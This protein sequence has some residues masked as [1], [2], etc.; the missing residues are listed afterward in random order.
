MPSA[1]RQSK[2]RPC[3]NFFG[4]HMLRVPGA[5]AG[6]MARHAPGQHH[7][8]RIG[9]MGPFRVFPDDITAW[10][11]SRSPVRHSPAD[12]KLST[13]APGPCG[14]KGNRQ[15][16]RQL[17]C[18]PRFARM[19]GRCPG[20]RAEMAAWSV[21]GSPAAAEAAN[22]L[23]GYGSN[24]TTC[25]VAQPSGAWSMILARNVLRLLF[26]FFL[27]RVDPSIKGESAVLDFL[28]FA[29]HRHHLVEALAGE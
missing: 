9:L 22:G 5:G 17:M 8:K 20:C 18:S 15:D 21:D 6:T 13:T 10:I 28:R 1:L 29:T 4:D 12:G 2:N 27:K 11:L 7:G 16:R 14:L 3:G 25:P 24:T 19:K 26:G 23:S